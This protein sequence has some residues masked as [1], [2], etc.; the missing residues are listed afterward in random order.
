MQKNNLAVHTF[1]Y[2]T[3]SD[4][5]K[6]ER[7]IHDSLVK[8]AE[9]VLEVVRAQWNKSGRIQACIIAWPGVEVLTDDGAPLDGPCLGVL[10]PIPPAERRALVERFAYRTN[11]YALLLI[12]QRAQAE[13]QAVFESPHGIRGWMLPLER[14]GDIWVATRPIMHSDPEPIGVIRRS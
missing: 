11:A 6:S 4:H 9:E 8:A 5:I 3:L 13:I 12:E 1:F 10:E 7:F 14:H 2:M